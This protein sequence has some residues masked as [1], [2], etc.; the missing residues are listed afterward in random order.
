[1]MFKESVTPKRP[2][3]NAIE[4][5]PKMR[6]G[7]VLSAVLG[8]T[9]DQFAE[10][11]ITQYAS[12]GAYSAHCAKQIAKT[13]ITK[14]PKWA[15]MHEFAHDLNDKN[16]ESTLLDDIQYGLSNNLSLVDA[17]IRQFKIHEIEPKDELAFYAF[18]DQE[19]EPDFNFYQLFLINEISR[20]IEEYRNVFSGIDGHSFMIVILNNLKKNIKDLTRQC[21]YLISNLRCGLVVVA[22]THEQ[23]WTG[24]EW[25]TDNE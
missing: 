24:K 16:L 20:A 4:S 17:Y 7:A 23:E 1:M 3:S 12:A 13:D 11:K 10:L 22:Q 25:K 21:F 9:P 8:Y 5:F 14:S 2:A 18:D 6:I 15:E 19:Q